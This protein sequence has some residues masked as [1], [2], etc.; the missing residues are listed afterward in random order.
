MFGAG[1]AAPRT[2]KEFAEVYTRAMSH[3][4]ATLIE[5]R[6]DRAE[7]LALHRALQTHVAQAV[8]AA[9]AASRG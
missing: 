6:T 3:A 7:N 1:Y 4:G 8:D 2:P 5:V 9:I